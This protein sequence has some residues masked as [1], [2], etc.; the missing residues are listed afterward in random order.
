MGTFTLTCNPIAG[1]IAAGAT[2]ALVGLRELLKSG[3][4]YDTKFTGCAL[5]SVNAAPNAAQEKEYIR[6][7]YN[8]SVDDFQVNAA[9]NRVELVPGRIH[10]TTRTMED[11]KAQAL[12]NIFTRLMFYESIGVP[13]NLLDTL[14][15]QFVF[16][17][18][19]D[20][21]EKTGIKMQQEFVE[22][23]GLNTP[24][25]TALTPEQRLVKIREVRESMISKRLEEVLRQERIIGEHTED[26]RHLDEQI[27]VRE[28]E[29]PDR[30]TK[31]Q[32]AAVA[33]KKEL[34]ERKAKLPDLTKYEEVDAL[35][36]KQNDLTAK[37]LREEGVV[38]PPGSDFITTTDS[39]I[40]RH[41]TEV[42]KLRNKLSRLETR[43]LNEAKTEADTAKNNYFTQLNTA[44]AAGVRVNTTGISDAMYNAM[45]TRAK[46][47]IEAKYAT[48][49]RT[50][51]QNMESEQSKI[52]ALKNIQNE[53]RQTET[54]RTQKEKEILTRAPVQLNEMQ[55][56]FDALFN[57]PAGFVGVPLTQAQLRDQSIDNLMA[58][59]KTPANGYNAIIP[60]PIFND[61]EI[62]RDYL[63][64]AKA[65]LKAQEYDDNSSDFSSPGDAL[66]NAMI[67]LP[68]G[69][70]RLDEIV[71]LSDQKIDRLLTQPPYGQV[72][73]VTTQIRE[74][75]KNEVRKRRLSRYRIF[76]E[77]QK[78]D[79]DRQIAEQEKI[80]KSDYKAELVYLNGVHEIVERQGHIFAA[81]DDIYD[82]HAEILNPAR[83]PRTTS[84]SGATPL[85]TYTESEQLSHAPIGYLELMKIFF[86]YQKEGDKRD[87]EFAKALQVLPPKDLAFL[88]NREMSLGLAGQQRYNLS[89]AL[90]ALNN[91]IT[92]TA[93]AAGV[94]APPLI[95]RLEIQQG[96]AGIINELVARANALS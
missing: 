81:S 37:L 84:R 23:L 24:A 49:K 70:L 30:K 13:G 5:K 27:R 90:T 29:T 50:L 17:P 57:L 41:Q 11:I 44:A 45:F 7:M 46:D 72:Y 42:V 65:E 54:E 85:S 10:Q 25:W 53:Y 18:D 1:L 38:I 74:V 61:N 89:Q 36:G 87:S 96:L 83:V 39:E 82:Q 56:Y 88:L 69:T 80:A 59:M 86:D 67:T 35:K 62:L 93:P 3:L 15:E 64:K 60:A 47:E 79:L 51:E 21:P 52:T 95:S 14:P 8:I 22:N 9:T 48:Q 40:N 28:G 33:K 4:T 58:Y 68:G 76:V 66:L 20:M 31:E 92:G 19:G 63:L 71:T 78:A 2:P 77:E 55:N 73:P 43:I 6:R 75:L 91:R 16:R 32:E 94:A 34:E 12:G 26:I